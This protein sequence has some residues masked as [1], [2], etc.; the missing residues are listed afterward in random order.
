[1]TEGEPMH[2]LLIEVDVGDVDREDGLRGL[3]AD[4]ACDRPRRLS[5]ARCA[6]VA[7]SANA[8]PGQR[9]R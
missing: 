3:R 5:D 9:Q 4:R 1:M 8:G 2:A 7:V 6:G